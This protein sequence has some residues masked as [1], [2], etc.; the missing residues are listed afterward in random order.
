MWAFGTARASADE[1]AA[2]WDQ[3][4]TDRGGEPAGFPLAIA[5][6]RPNHIRESNSLAGKIW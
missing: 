2:A 6:G 1:W 4:C 5:S 3:F